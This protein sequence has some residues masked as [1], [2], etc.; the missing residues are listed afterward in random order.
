MT[1]VLREDDFAF[2]LEREIA[3]SG[4]AIAA[5]VIDRENSMLIHPLFAEWRITTTH[6]AQ[7]RLFDPTTLLLGAY[8]RSALT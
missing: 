1:V 3:R 7:L 8:L 5:K 6:V 2:R 4:N